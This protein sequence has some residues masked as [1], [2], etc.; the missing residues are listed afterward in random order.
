MKRDLLAKLA[1]EKNGYLFTKDVVSVGIS[2]TY[3]A[4]FVKTNGFEKVAPGIYIA[5]D[6]ILP[7]ELF[8]LQSANPKMVFSGITAL[9]LNNMID[10][11][12]LDIEAYVPRGYNYYHLT[13]KGIHIKT[14]IPELYLLGQ[15]RLKSISGNEVISYDR[16]RCI[17][18]AIINRSNIEIQLFQSAIKDYMNSKSR[19]FDVLVNYGKA[20]NI[21]DE[22]MKY[23]EVFT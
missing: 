5:P 3:L 10:S 1:D 13:Q 9:Y 12:Y 18:D 4:S 2:K 17:C 11:E 19:K 21:H 14:M 6:I 16:E 23:I 15:T 22:I 8:V 20:L 7:D